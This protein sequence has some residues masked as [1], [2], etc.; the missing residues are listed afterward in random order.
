MSRVAALTARVSSRAT[1]RSASSSADAPSSRS[2]LVPTA[3]RAPAPLAASPDD[4]AQLAV[5]ATVGAALVTLAW[6]SIRAEL[7]PIRCAACRGV[8]WVVCPNCNGRGKTGC[9]PLAAATMGL[10]ARPGVEC[11]DTRPRAGKG[12]APDD[13]NAET[14]AVD[15]DDRLTYCRACGGRGR[16]KCVA[17]AGAGVENHWLYGPADNPGWGPRGEGRDPNKPP[18]PP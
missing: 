15:D 1:P 12:S 4:A 6:P 3:R 2:V 9:P 7:K 13:A 8:G 17:C 10:R 14:C 5:G 18:P 16:I 11:D